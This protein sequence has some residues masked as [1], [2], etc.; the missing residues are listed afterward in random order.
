MATCKKI[1]NNDP[2]IKLLMGMKII[3][4]NRQVA[5]QD[6]L[7]LECV[8]ELVNRVLDLEGEFLFSLL[9]FFL[10]YF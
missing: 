7:K 8:K 1:P 6:L 10:L 3:R 9:F 5:V 2:A 4:T